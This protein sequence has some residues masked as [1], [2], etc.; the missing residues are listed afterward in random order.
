M[1]HGKNGQDQHI[2]IQ[3]LRR[4]PR[5]MTADVTA[6]INCIERKT[7]AATGT[8]LLDPK[9]SSQGNLAVLV[10][11]CNART[12]DVA[13][14]AILLASK[15]ELLLHKITVAPSYRRKRIGTRLLEGVIH[16]APRASSRNVVL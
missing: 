3:E 15:H 13:G 11:S 2:T 14:Y 4:L 16:R 5:D 6:K 9:N 10:A 1:A 7:F 12:A 8:L